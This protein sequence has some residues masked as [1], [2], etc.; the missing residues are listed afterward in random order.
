MLWTI[1]VILAIVVLAI[2]VLNF[3]MGRGPR[4]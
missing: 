1:L 2:F 4:V 3:V